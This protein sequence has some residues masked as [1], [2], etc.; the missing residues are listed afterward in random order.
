MQP[1]R[2]GTMMMI[3]PEAIART[4]RSGHA[5][6]AAVYGAAADMWWPHRQSDATTLAWAIGLQWMENIT[7]DG[8]WLWSAWGTAPNSKAKLLDRYCVSHMGP[9]SRA[10]PRPWRS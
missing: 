5:K 7:S 2:E 8:W 1:G 3:D 6:A 10:P 4:F 9:E